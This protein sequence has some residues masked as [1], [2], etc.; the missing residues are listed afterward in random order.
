MPL[1]Q[2]EDVNAWRLIRYIPTM[3]LELTKAD[4]KTQGATMELNLTSSA[5]FDFACVND[6]DST[7]DPN[8]PYQVVSKFRFTSWLDSTVTEKEK[9]HQ[10]NFSGGSDTYLHFL[11]EFESHKESGLPIS[12]A[13]RMEGLGDKPLGST[14]VLK[15]PK[16]SKAKVEFDKDKKR[17]IWTLNIEDYEDDYLAIAF[18]DD[19]WGGDLPLNMVH[20]GTTSH[21]HRFKIERD[22]NNQ[23]VIPIDLTQFDKNQ[24]LAQMHM[25]DGTVELYPKLSFLCQTDESLLF[26]E[27]SGVKGAIAQDLLNKFK[28]D[29]FQFY[30]KS[31][32]DIERLVLTNDY[33]EGL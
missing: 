26:P 23:V 22:G 27:S 12:P 17:A 15:Y 33:I 16:F 32:S 25:F 9:A 2:F 1:N 24:L 20:S 13:I 29:N 10:V 30:S 28:P 4:N 5:A 19:Q 8:F 31:N 18:E 6:E 3:G 21:W 14:L 7:G 11:K